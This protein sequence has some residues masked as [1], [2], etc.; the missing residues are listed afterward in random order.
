MDQTTTEKASDS[1]AATALLDEAKNAAG[2]VV[3]TATEQ[4]GRRLDSEKNKAA[5]AIGGVADAI[6]S[7]AERH[8]APG[9]AGELGTR[10]ADGIEDVADYLQ[11]R[12]LRDVIGEVESFARREPAIFLGAAFALGLVGGR[13]LKSSARSR[14]DAR[15]ALGASEHSRTLMSRGAPLEAASPGDGGRGMERGGQVHGT[16]ERAAAGDA[17]RGTS[18]SI[19]VASTGNTDAVRAV[20]AAATNAAAATSAAATSTGN[21]GFKATGTDG[22]KSAPTNAQAS[23]AGSSNMPAAQ[24]AEAKK[25]APGAPSNG[26]GDKG[27]TDGGNRSIRAGGE[28]HS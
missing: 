20:S 23:A 14:T 28:G 3:Q 24:G 4:I 22:E 12:S 9:P 26:S 15:H 27:R 6:R 10:A 16:N 18:S 25:A 8:S 17:Q 13:F 21:A 2:K 5:D 1:G 19:G 11:S 7:T